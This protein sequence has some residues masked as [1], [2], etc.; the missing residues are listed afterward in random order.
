MDVNSTT[1]GCMKYTDVSPTYFLR[2]TVRNECLYP[3]GL[4]SWSQVAALPIGAISIF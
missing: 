4:F 2:I 3:L 1:E